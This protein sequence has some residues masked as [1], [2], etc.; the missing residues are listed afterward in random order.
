MTSPTSGATAATSLAPR[1]LLAALA[2]VI[3]WGLNFIAMKWALES[4]TPFELGAVRYVFAA[5]PMVLLVR[6]PRIGWRWVVGLG[7]FQGVMQFSFGFF[8]LKV[9]MTAA[10]ASVLMQTQVFF[11]A[12]F[13]FFMLRESPSRPLL[14]GMALAA[15]GLVC[16]AMNFVGPG[17]D[18]PGASGGVTPFAILLTLCAAMSWAVSNIVARLAQKTA[19]GFDPLAMVVWSCPAPV[20]AFAAL[21]F[22]TDASSIRWMHAEAWAALPW[23][24]WGSVAY[25][26]WIATISA[27]SMWTRLL[28]RYPANQVAPFSL[29]VPV[30]GLAA[31]MLVLDETVTGWQ[32]IG[33][34]FVVAALVCVV[35][36]GRWAQRRHS[37]LAAPPAT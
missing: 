6:P 24:A 18:L 13:A 35:L 33:T 19:P 32:W 26:G 30:V 22:F 9:G 10:L 34:A 27:Y 16:F 31:G 11:T 4:F 8:A 5:L 29:G 37:A 25:L 2:V 17:A 1:D 21:A 14:I 28:T 7:L 36:G 3:I 20:L 12:L 15:V 23:A